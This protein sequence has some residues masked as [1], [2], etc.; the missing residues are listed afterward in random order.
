MVRQSKSSGR[1]RSSPSGSGRGKG[2][3]RG[4]SAGGHRE[5]GDRTSKDAETL[6]PGGMGGS[7][8]A[9]REIEDED[10]LSPGGLG[11]GEEELDFDESGGLDPERDFDPR[12]RDGSGLS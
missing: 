11:D 6:R 7:P 3:S 12:A 1:S 8:G 4:G 10:E 2:M 9:L 5:Q